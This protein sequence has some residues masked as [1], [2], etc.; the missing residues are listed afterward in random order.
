MPNVAS[1]AFLIW[2]F[3]SI[4]GAT[5]AYAQNVNVGDALR[6]ATAARLSGDIDQARTLLEAVLEVDPQNISGL[7][8]YGLIQAYNSEYKAALETLEYADHLDNASNSDIDLAIARVLGWMGEVDRAIEQARTVYDSGVSPVESNIVLGTLNYY[9]GDFDA[10]LSFFEVAQYLAPENPEIVAGL[11]RV[12]QAQRSQ[13]EII[14][15]DE[16]STTGN[17]TLIG[18]EYSSFSDSSRGAW[19]EIFVTLQS[20]LNDSAD[21]SITVRRKSRFNAIDQTYQ[22]GVR[23]RMAENVQVRAEVWH[24]PASDFSEKWAVLLHGVYTQADLTPLGS[25]LFSLGGGRKIYNTNMVDPLDIGIT[26]YLGQRVWITAQSL[27]VYDHS[28]QDA[29]HGYRLNFNALPLWNLR[30]RAS[31]SAADEAS[32]QEVATVRSKSVSASLDLTPT[33]SLNASF[34]DERREGG[35]TRYISSISLSAAL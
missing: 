31:Y 19:R 26:Q 22:F 35:V 20:T 14:T 18:Y 24:T 34:G 2:L 30:L 28:V 4:V 11:Q 6:D 21:G 12:R 17:R 1:A 7:F 13:V 9:R 27:N 29:L 8:H 33:I 32:D 23:H 15:N 5:Q 10:A 25:T 16:V 3:A